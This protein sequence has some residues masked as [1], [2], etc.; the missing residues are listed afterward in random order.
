MGLPRSIVNLNHTTALKDIQVRI[1]EGVLG[2]A[3]LNDLNRETQLTIK[4]RLNVTPLAD[5]TLNVGY[6]KDSGIPVAGVTS[7]VRR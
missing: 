7:P 4:D 3:G 5:T 2:T 1:P 6:L